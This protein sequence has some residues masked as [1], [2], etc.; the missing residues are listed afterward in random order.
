MKGHKMVVKSIIKMGYKMVLSALAAAVLTGLAGCAGMGKSSCDVV[1]LKVNYRTNP[2]GIEG[3]PLFSWRM[4]DET[5]GQRQTAYRVVVGESEAN[6]DVGKYIWDSGKVETDISV[7]IPY[8]GETLQAESGYFWKVSVWDKDGRAAE[9]AECAYFETGAD[10][11]WC[12]AKWI[13]IKAD[14]YKTAE[15]SYTIEYD[16]RMDNG[17]SGFVWGADNFSYGEYLRCGLNILDDGIWLVISE[18]CGNVTENETRINL[19]ESLTDYFPDR[20]HFTDVPHHMKLQVRGQ[21]V[22]V[23]MDGIYVCAYH[24]TGENRGIGQIGL[25]T[26]RGAY[27]ACYDNIYIQDD[28]SGDILYDEG[29]G[30]KNDN[31]FSPFYVKVVDGWCEAS[32]GYLFTDEG[33]RPAP[34]FRKSFGLD[35]DKTIESARLYAAALGTYDIYVNGQDACDAYMAPGC[36]VYRDAV[37]YRVYDIAEFLNGGYDDATENVIGIMLGHGRYNRATNCSWGEDLAFCAK[38]VVNY[39]DGSSRVIVTDG[40]WEAFGDGPVRNDDLFSGEY[41]DANFEQTGWSEN[42]FDNGSWQTVTVYDE[43]DSLKK[44]AAE[45]EPVACIG[46]L[47]PIAVTEPAAREYVYDFGQNFNGNCSITLRGTEGKAGQVVIMRYAE[48]VNTG[49]MSCA[50]DAVGAVWT[51]NLYT[52]DNTDY[53]VLKGSGEERYTP[54]FVYRGFRYVQ[55]SGIDGELL[56]AGDVKGLVIS[57]DNE[58][59]GFFTCSDEKINKLYESIYWTQL[60][61]YVDIPTDCPQR[62]ERLGWAGDAQVFARTAAY[63]A[64]IYTFMEKYVDMIRTGQSENGAFPDIAPGIGTGNSANGWGDAGIILVWELYQQYGNP[65]IIREN[66]GAMCRYMDYL[67]ETSDNFIRAE[68]GYGDHN[69]VSGLDDDIANTAQCAYVALLLSKMCSAVGEDDI[70]GRY[71][72]VYDQYKRAWQEAYINEDGTMDCWLQSAYTLGL[73]FGLY[74]DEL[75][76]KGAEHLNT[77]VMANDYH[78]NTGYIATPFVLPILCEYGYADTAYR[79]LMQDTY[80]SWNDM[81]SRGGTTITEAWFTYYD[82]GGGTY[83]I[84]GSLNHCALGSVGQWLYSDMAGIKRDEKAPSYKHFYIEPIVGG[85]ITFAS[86]SYKSMY[87]TIESSWHVEG[88]ELVFNVTI[89]ANTSATVSLPAPDYRGMELASGKYEYRIANQK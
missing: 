84:N 1:D 45:S 8:E 83:R 89:P 2:M 52:A 4:E 80:P 38:L 66:L 88:D 73:A 27:Q 63:N 10:E 48:A 41:Y 35:K 54:S 40:T 13:G 81:L 64:D 37:Y 7:A 53:Y 36:S 59:T 50:D 9:A 70:A 39:T 16:I 78:L 17:S 51:Q 29:F 5:K 15:T 31:I 55:I 3:I 28:T 18:F 85:G 57:T 43:Y 69:A 22:D 6:L 25:W 34:M 68:K 61:N 74:P 19:L 76:D 58:R 77:A 11:D 44:I 42:G 71:A 33:G 60:S 79:L 12:G 30:D 86:G 62:D 67:V 47:D 21:K 46:Q 56:A 75:R 32:S 26:A 65:E 24:D 49:N 23:F 87:G 20:E 82:T 72:L 14:K